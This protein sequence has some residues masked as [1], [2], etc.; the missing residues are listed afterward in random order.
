M[1]A[2]SFAWSTGVSFSAEA[3]ADP[4]SSF[5]EALRLFKSGS[6]EQSAELAVENA[7][8]SAGTPWE[9]RSLFIAGRAY[10]EAGNPDLALGYL[11][12]AEKN[13]AA[14]ADYALFMQAEYLNKS[15]RYEEAAPVCMRVADGYPKGALAALSLLDAGRAYVE[16]GGYAEGLQALKRFLDRGPGQQTA[17]EAHYLMMLASEGLG[18]YEQ[19]FSH[20]RTLWLE[21]PG[22]WPEKRAADIIA[23]LAESGYMLAVPG[24]E[25]HLWRAEKLSELGRYK[26]A[27]EDFKGSLE[28]MPAGHPDEG[29]ALAGLGYAYYKLR[30]NERAIGVLSRFRAG[31]E[32]PK[33]SPEALYWLARA[34]LRTGREEEF[35]AAA[36]EC[37][38]GYPE[39][40]RASGCLYLLGSEHTFSG[41]YGDAAETFGGLL[42]SYPGSGLADDALWRLGWAEYLAGCYP[43]AEKTFQEFAVKYPNSPLIAQALYWRARSLGNMGEDDTAGM[44][45]ELLRCEYRLSYYAV[46][47][48]DPGGPLSQDA[49]VAAPSAAP[50]MKKTYP[51]G[52]PAFGRAEELGI[53]GMEQYAVRELKAVESR[54]SGT[55]DGIKTMASAYIAAGN[56]KYTIEMSSRLYRTSVST[57]SSIVPDDALRLIFPLAFWDVIH[58]EADRFGVDPFLVSSLAREESHFDPRA[59]SPAGAVGLM[60]LMPSTAA[61]VCRLLDIEGPTT[62]KLKSEDFNVPVGT[63]HL[64]Y[65]LEKQG[66]RLVYVLGEYN[67][68][69]GPLARWKANNPDV[70]DDVFVECI[71]YPETRNYVKRVLRNYKVYRDLYGV[72]VSEP[73]AK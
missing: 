69:P 17:A 14:I 3:P 51:S 32:F 22:S 31:G 6:F 29:R 11:E 12:L 50:D 18:D 56:F 20:Y 10:G 67:A 68:G 45:Y 53:Q 36:R 40:G 39:H 21:Y 57:G 24:I 8:L 44:I 43:E 62:G 19:V 72:A 1:V 73:E 64:G 58:T 2:L 34:Y 60:Q 63:C 49:G 41:R 30:E 42:E 4:A 25:N 26:G 9:G 48:E 70:P 59:E 16:S 13:Y 38:E 28:L 5:G 66:G 35:I 27:V 46:L 61:A 54:Y 55:L 33:Q 47:A 52:E 7:S 37:A 23:R 15:G 65:L 71:T